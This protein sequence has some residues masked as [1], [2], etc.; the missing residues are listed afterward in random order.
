MADG[1]CYEIDETSST[2]NTNDYTNAYIDCDTCIGANPTPTPTPSP[3]PTPTPGGCNEWDLEGGPG[4]VGN[5]SYTD[6][7]GVSQTESVDDGDSSSVCA[8]GVP[9]LSSG[10]G[11]VTLVGV[12]VTPTPTPVTPTPTP[13]PGGPTPTPTPTP[14]PTV[15]YDDYTITRCDGGFNNYT[16]GRALANTFPTNDSLLMPDGN[17]YQIIDPTGTLGTLAS[18]VYTNCISCNAPTPTPTT[19]LPTRTPTPTPTPTPSPT[20]T[21]G[22][23]TPT[24]SPTPMPGVP[25]PTPTPTPE[26]P[27]PTPTP[28]PT[29]SPTAGPTPTPSPSPTPTPT[30]TPTPTPGACIAIE[31]GFSTGLYNGCCAPPDSSGIKYFNA[32]SVASAT[33]LYSGLGCTELDRGTIYVSEDGSTYYEFFN[34]VKTAG[35]TSCPSCP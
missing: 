29:P 5:F 16:V 9:T 8:L 34:G 33:R 1:K 32:N 14:I 13:T 11:T 18:A 7:S 30:A 22:V 3:T 12:C 17:C 24:P 27:T 21:P 28:S 4:L 2:V 26:G 10:N 23:P 19:E 6:C 15:A 20:P 35:P 31:V 25:T